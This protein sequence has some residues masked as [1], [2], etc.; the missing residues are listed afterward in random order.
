[1][2]NQTLSLVPNGLFLVMGY[3]AAISSLLFM[4]IF[5]V[6][7]IFLVIFRPRT[8]YLHDEDEFQSE[9]NLTVSENETHELGNDKK[10]DINQSTTLSTCMNSSQ[11]DFDELKTR[12][13]TNLIS[14]N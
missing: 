11:L 3:L 8:K 4:T 14:S 9:T 5:V 12:S 2:N 13:T 1:M 6:L 10:W 7:I